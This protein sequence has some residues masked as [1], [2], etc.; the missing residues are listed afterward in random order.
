MRGCFALTGSGWFES[1]QSRGHW[2]EVNFWQ[3]RGGT[4]LN[5]PIGTPFFFKLHAASGS[6]IVGFGYFSWRV[7]TECLAR[8]TSYPIQAPERGHALER[9]RFGN[10]HLTTPGLGQGGFRVAVM[11]A[12][13]R[14]CAICSEHSLPA[15]EAAH[16][17]IW[18][19]TRRFVA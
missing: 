16:Q 6:W 12:Y 5:P 7:F 3:P 1:L 18:H 2:E 11:D 10:P 14:A 9:A 17:A 15:L 13:G 19:A 4:L 8:T